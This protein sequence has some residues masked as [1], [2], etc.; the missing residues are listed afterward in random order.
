[1][2]QSYE[3]SIIYVDDSLIIAMMQVSLDLR[4]SRISWMLIIC[5]DFIPCCLLEVTHR[6]M[7]GYNLRCSRVIE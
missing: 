7:I 5:F 1:M 6:V 2:R 3:L 4:C